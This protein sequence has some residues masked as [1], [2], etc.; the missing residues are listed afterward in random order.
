MKDKASG[1]IFHLAYPVIMVF[2]E[3]TV[4]SGISSNNWRACSSSPP[5]QLNVMALFADTMS[6]YVEVELGFSFQPWCFQ[7]PENEDGS[8]AVLI[9]FLRFVKYSGRSR[10]I[11]RN[12][13]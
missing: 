9:D 4:R 7:V 8:S 2:Q 6:E 10:D 13:V 5:W 3:T 12:K 1:Y 11:E